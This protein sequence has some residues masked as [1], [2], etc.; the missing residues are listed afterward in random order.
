ME[1]SNVLA[2]CSITGKILQLPGA[3]RNK[4][5]LTLVTCNVIPKLLLIFPG[6]IHLRKGFLGG[7]L[8]GRAYI[9]RGLETE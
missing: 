9:Q 4:R 2:E 8:N 3:H 1:P 6:F 5:R 7:L